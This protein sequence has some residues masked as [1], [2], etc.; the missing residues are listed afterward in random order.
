MPKIHVKKESFDKILG[1]VLTIDELV[2][3]GFEYGI[4]I[5]EDEQDKTKVIF[6]IG[7]NRHDLSCVEGLAEAV[8]VY[9]GLRDIPNYKTIPVQTREKIIVKQPTQTVRPFVVGAILRNITF[10]QD[11]YD[12][13]IELQDKLHHNICRKR[14]QVAIGT[15]DYDTVKGPFTYTAL[16]PTDIKFK[17]LN[18]TEEMD[19]EKLMKFYETDNKLKEFLP[20]I[21]DSPVYPVILDANNVVCSLPP[22]INGD[23]SKIKLT[24]KNVFI[25]CTATDYTKALVVLNIMVTMFSRYCAEGYTFEQVDVVYEHNNETKITPEVTIREIETEIKYIN[26]LIGIDIDA[27]TAVTLLKKMGLNGKKVSAEKISVEV[28]INRSDILHSCDIAE[29]VGIGYGINNIPFTYPPSATTGGQLT[30]NKIG[31]LVRQEVAQAGYSECLNFALC[32]IAEITE[33]INRKNG[34]E[35]A[36]QIANPK[37]KEFQVG[38]TTLLPGLLKS[39]ASNRA[40]KLPLNLFEVGDVILKA[41][42]EAG[43]RNERRLACIH[44]NENSSGFELIHGVLDYIMLKLNISNDKKKAVHYSI[45]ESKNGTFFPGMQAE[46]L[47]SGKVIGSFGILHPEVLNNF[48][49]SYPAS[50]VELNLEALVYDGFL[51]SH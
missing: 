7:A 28:P 41:D 44:T 11:R 49:W 48:N 39:V 20:I 9:Y 29:D 42:N 8:G 4:E 46:V 40:N 18:Q 6:E 25:E 13:F 10:D 45:S 1:K 33:N 27:E 37:T 31:D 5:E 50:Y 19:G 3:F 36:V 15:H 21:R 22:I 14:T 51:K 12:S 23:H 35:E 24:T 32:S 26:T 38:R 47:L 34:L 17:P 43:S 2:N 16:P 30:I